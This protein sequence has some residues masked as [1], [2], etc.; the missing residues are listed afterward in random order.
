MML[1]S[2]VGLCR[3]STTIPLNE[4]DMVVEGERI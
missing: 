2:T 3:A 1:V 4:Q